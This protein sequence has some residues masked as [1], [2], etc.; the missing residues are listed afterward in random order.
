M[1]VLFRVA[2]YLMSWRGLRRLYVMA[3]TRHNVGLI[4]RHSHVLF[5][6]VTEKLHGKFD[7]DKIYASRILLDVDQNYSHKRAGFKSCE[8][9][10]HWCSSRYFMNEVC[11][12][13][14]NN[15]HLGAISPPFW[16]LAFYCK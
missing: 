1:Y 9:Y 16:G 4:R 6:P 3:M 13:S 10:Y 5:G 12:L 7:K 15:K 11:I 2:P 14:N 8:E